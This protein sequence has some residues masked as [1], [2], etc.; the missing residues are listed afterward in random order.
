MKV[1]SFLFAI[2]IDQ[3]GEAYRFV[4]RIL[5][6]VNREKQL[7]LLTRV[8][9]QNGYAVTLIDASIRS[10]YSLLADKNKV[11]CLHRDGWLLFA[12]HAK[13]LSEIAAWIDS[14]VGDA[15]SEFAASTIP[16]QSHMWLDVDTIRSTLPP[17]LQMY[18]FKLLLDRGSESK[19]RRELLSNISSWLTAF[20]PFEEG[21]IS[22][23]SSSDKT[24]IDFHIGGDE[25]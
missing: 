4:N 22:L 8:S 1:P 3:E 24:I 21:R 18:K 15:R 6:E 23:Y 5:D 9:V 25:Q 16:G 2:P 17:L 14:G 19:T 13:A 12:S 7:G 10:P 11:A 20:E